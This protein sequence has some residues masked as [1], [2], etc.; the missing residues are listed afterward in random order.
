MPHQFF[1]V[2]IGIKQGCQNF[3]G[4]RHIFLNLNLVPLIL[5]FLEFIVIKYIPENKTLL[6]RWNSLIAVNISAKI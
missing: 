4:T 2:D 3:I 6:I 5:G 1:L